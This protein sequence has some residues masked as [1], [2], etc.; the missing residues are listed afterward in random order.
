MPE[1]PLGW[2]SPCSDGRYKLTFERD[3]PNGPNEVW[4]AMTSEEYVACWLSEAEIELR[5]M[6]RLRLRGQCNVDG[7]VLEVQ[8]PALFGW[9]WPHPD[10]P[11]SEVHISIAAL[12]LAASRVTLVQTNLPGRHILDVATGWHTHLDA[13]PAAV[14]GSHT[15]FDAE[16]A[17]I[18][19]RR[20]SAS[21]AKEVR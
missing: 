11:A 13:L 16:L 6:G 2:I 10:H 17:A 12:D 20:Y 3:L 15:P 21:L 1:A 14:L 4:R 5:P 19:Y 18:N 7:E 9:T 8:A